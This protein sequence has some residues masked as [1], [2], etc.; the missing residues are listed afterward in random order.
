MQWRIITHVRERL[1]DWAARRRNAGHPD[2]PK[3][4][5]RRPTGHQLRDH[6]THAP[7]HGDD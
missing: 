6:H 5:P 7:H 1:T 4:K 2:H 3:R